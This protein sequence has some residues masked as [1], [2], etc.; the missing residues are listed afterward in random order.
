MK[1]PR[2]DTRLNWRDP[3]MPVCREYVMRDGTVKGPFVDQDYE[4]R[5]REHMMKNAEALDW[6]SDPTYNLRKRKR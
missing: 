6:R 2:P 3:N 1:R 4:H 5:Y